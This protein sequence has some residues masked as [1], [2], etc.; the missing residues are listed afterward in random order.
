MRIVT[1]PPRH[2]ES[3]MLA[4][5]SYAD[6]SGFG[7]LGA[8]RI[9]SALVFAPRG[10]AYMPSVGDN[11]LLLPIEGRDVCVGALTSPTG[12]APGELRLTSAGG[13]TIRL[14]AN[15]EIHLNGAVITRDGR[16][17]SR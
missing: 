16:V 3:G 4:Q 17:I 2:Q 11:L 10:I 14:A 5:V 12:L 7:V 9:S 8:S 13:A 6:S 1:D 15:G